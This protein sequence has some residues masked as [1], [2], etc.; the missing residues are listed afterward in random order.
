MTFDGPN[1]LVIL[2]STSLVL[3]T[4][5]SDYKAWLRAGNA[6][7]ALAMD[8]EG[9]RP[10]DPAAGTLTPLVVFL[11]N[12]W[13]I[14]PMEADHTVT[15]TGGTLVDES[16]GDPFISTLGGY[17]VRIRYQQPVQA[18]GY[19]TTGTTGPSAGDIAAAVVAALQLTTTPA[20]V[21][22]ING[23]QVVGTGQSGDK[24][25]GLGV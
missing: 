7:Y 3:A 12:G 22:L 20:D 24:W 8:T 18:I 19:S 1:K 13:K 21:R 25:R 10:I 4:L 16:G 17:T 15:V 9:G 23:A 6:G 14:R 2:S 11:R 5:W